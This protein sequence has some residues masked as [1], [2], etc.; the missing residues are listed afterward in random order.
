MLAYIALVDRAIF[1]KSIAD[2]GE[3]CGP[4]FIC[5]VHYIKKMVWKPSRRLLCCCKLTAFCSPLLRHNSIC[6]FLAILPMLAD[7]AFAAGLTVSAIKT[8]G[9]AG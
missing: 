1:A 3:P 2:A 8:P 9:G 7:A 4:F 6:Q 5:G